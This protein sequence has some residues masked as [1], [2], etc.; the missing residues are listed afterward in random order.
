VG[1]Q[2]A[3]E[4]SPDAIIK[5]AALFYKKR[6]MFTPDYYVEETANWIVFPWEI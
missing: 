5:T 1:Y 4:T 6:A 2:F 3:Q